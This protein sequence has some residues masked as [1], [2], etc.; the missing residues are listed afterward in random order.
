MTTRTVLVAAT[1]LLKGPVRRGPDAVDP[2]AAGRDYGAVH[3]R[4]RARLRRRRQRPPPGSRPA[5][6]NA[7]LDPAAR[8]PRSAA[9][10][11]ARRRFARLARSARPLG[12][13]QRRRFEDRAPATPAAPLPRCPGSRDSDDGD[14]D[15]WR[16]GRTPRRPRNCILER[17]TYRC[18]RISATHSIPNLELDSIAL[19]GTASAGCGRLADAARHGLGGFR[20]SAE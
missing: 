1:L 13:V 2:Q 8:H 7:K 17:V 3:H 5:D 9:R 20:S 10:T 14:A 19:C 16:S 11:R 6:R 15:T 12:E 4:R 18:H